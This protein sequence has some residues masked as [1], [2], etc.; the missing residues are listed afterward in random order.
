MTVTSLDEQLNKLPADLQHKCRLTACL[1]E[2]PIVLDPR[3]MLLQ[4]IVRMFMY[5][6]LNSNTRELFMKYMS[7]NLGF[8]YVSVGYA[9]LH[10]VLKPLYI[11]LISEYTFDELCD[12]TKY[13]Y[14][15]GCYSDH[16][17]LT[18]AGC[19]VAICYGGSYPPIFDPS[20]SCHGQDCYNFTIEDYQRFLDLINRFDPIKV[21]NARSKHRKN[22]YQDWMRYCNGDIYKIFKMLYGKA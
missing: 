5:W 10:H 4:S 11:A 3:K 15:S 14:Y 16:C 17:G 9:R 8:F 7:H 13:T 1:S 6:Y 20:C 18:M 19:S 21:R 22:R 12:I 2:L